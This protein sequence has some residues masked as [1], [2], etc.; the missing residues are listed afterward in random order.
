MYKLTIIPAS[1]HHHEGHHRECVQRHHLHRQYYLRCLL[2]QLVCQ[3]YHA[4]GQLPSEHYAYFAE[5]RCCL[6]R[7]REQLDVGW[8]FD[9]YQ[10]D[11]D[12]CECYCFAD[13]VAKLHCR[14]VNHSGG[15]WHLIQGR[16]RQA[17][18]ACHGWHGLFR[19]AGLLL[20]I[21]AR[22]RSLISF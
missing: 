9:L 14:S 20:V 2:C 10:H 3:C 8:S 21:G 22:H 15:W 11:H 6:A 19:R 7:H 18:R 16:W 1:C 12:I 17:G 4:Y 13:V 5:Q